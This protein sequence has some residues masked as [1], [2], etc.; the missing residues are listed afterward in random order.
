MMTKSAALGLARSAAIPASLSLGVM[1][2][3]AQSTFGEVSAPHH[4]V[5]ALPMAVPAYLG[6]KSV[7]TGYDHIIF[8]I[9]MIYPVARSRPPS[10]ALLWFMVG[11]ATAMIVVGLFGSLV[12]IAAVQIIVANSIVALALLNMNA[13]QT[14]FGFGPSRTSLTF[15]SSLFHGLCIST[16]TGFG[17]HYSIGEVISAISLLA[18]ITAFLCYSSWI[19][20]IAVGYC[21]RFTGYGE[22]GLQINIAIMVFGMCLIGLR[23]AGL[24]LGVAA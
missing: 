13:F 17:D 16:H 10:I 21:R 24:L 23:M 5:D 2:A 9:G 6:A 14:W 3:I 15:I 20:S 12:D 4:M 22:I 1:G 7:A 19:F 18:G 11:V 8:L